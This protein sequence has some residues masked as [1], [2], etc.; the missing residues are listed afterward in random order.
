[1]NK[2]QI[3]TADKNTTDAMGQMYITLKYGELEIMSS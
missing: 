3:Q 2:L 1:M